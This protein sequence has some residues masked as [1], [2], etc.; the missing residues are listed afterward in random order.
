MRRLAL[1]LV[2]LVVLALGLGL[3]V[4]GAVPSSAAQVNGTGLSE[5]A[6]ADQLSV[7]RGHRSFLCYLAAQQYIES[8][9]AASLRASNGAIAASSST[10]L[11]ALWLNQRIDAEI[12]HQAVAAHG[13]LPL[14]SAAITRAEQ[15]LASTMDSVLQ[16]YQCGVSSGVQLLASLP[17]GFAEQLVVAQAEDE[18]LLSATRGLISNDKVKAYFD[19]HGS[20]FDTYCVSAILL[21][22]KAQADSVR[23]KITGGLSFADAAKQYSQDSSSAPSGGDLGCFSPGSTNYSSVASFVST[24]P[25]G[26]VSKTIANGTNGFVLLEVTKRTPATLAQ[27]TSSIQRILLQEEARQLI[28]AAQVSVDPRYGTWSTTTVV[29]RVVP[30]A[31]PAASSLLNVRAILPGAGGF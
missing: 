22:S 15:D 10:E 30:P 5:K 18:A 31:A 23:Q 13:G 16:R 24:L 21:P 1:P 14:S 8:N 2:V 11:A 12:T 19:A 17:S 27:A 4:G 26:T 28:V 7:I 3:F 25:V 9:G 29:P 6:F 20:D